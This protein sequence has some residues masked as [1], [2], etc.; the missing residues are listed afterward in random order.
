MNAIQLMKKKHLKKSH[1]HLWQLFSANNKENDFNIIKKILFSLSSRKRKDVHCYHCYSTS[2]WKFKPVQ[3]EKE[4]NIDC[5]E[6]L[7]LFTDFFI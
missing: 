6:N 5:K 2:Y 7:S 4:K 1:T 3:W